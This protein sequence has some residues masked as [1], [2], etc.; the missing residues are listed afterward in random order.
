ML[1]LLLGLILAG[2]IPSFSDAQQCPP[3]ITIDKKPQVFIMSDISNEPDDTMSFIRLLLHSDQ[4]NITG[5]VAVVCT[6][7]QG[8]QPKTLTYIDYSNRLLTG[9]TRPYTRIRS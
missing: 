1:C 3:A 2:L 7:H 6:S 4:Y 8:N 5:M 9:R